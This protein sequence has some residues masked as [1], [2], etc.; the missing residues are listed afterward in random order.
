MVACGL[1]DRRDLH[2]LGA[3]H[4]EVVDRQRLEEPASVAGVAEHDGARDLDL[5]HGDLPPV[6]GGVGNPSGPPGFHRGCPAK[7]P[8]GAPAARCL[9][10][11]PGR[12]TGNK[13]RVM[14]TQQ[15][16][17]SR[18]GGAGEYRRF[19]DPEQLICPGCGE[20]VHPEQPG[21]SGG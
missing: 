18:Y 12:C 10:P 6:P 16:T 2:L 14:A 3:A 17:S 5:A 1:C 21:Y 8:G 11:V 4:I 9:L 15:H 7:N 13:G 20:Q 19:V